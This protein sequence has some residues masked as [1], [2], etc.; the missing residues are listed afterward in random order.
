MGNDSAPV[1][2]YDGDCSFCTASAEWVAARWE[3]P[4]SAVAWQSLAPGELERL[5]L[6]IDDVR[7]AAWW[8]DE[9]GRRSRGHLAIVQALAATSGWSAVCGRLLL[10]PPFRWLGAAV[11]PV[12]ARWR[13]RLPGGTPAC[14]M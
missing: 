13:H 12:L 4:A 8:I 11:Y 3:G 5:G 14:R 7:T 10:I 2:V 9:T 1:L 6:S